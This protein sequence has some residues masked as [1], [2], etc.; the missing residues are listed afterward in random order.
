MDKIQKIHHLI[1]TG[2]GVK[3]S[4]MSFKN[5]ILICTKDSMPSNA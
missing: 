4:I 2:K 5:K 1:K 3:M